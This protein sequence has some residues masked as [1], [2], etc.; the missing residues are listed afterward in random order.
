[1][2]TLFRKLARWLS[3][4]RDDLEPDHDEMGHYR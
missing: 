3:I 4:T 2:K 1:M